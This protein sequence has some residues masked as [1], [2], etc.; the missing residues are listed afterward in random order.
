M[1]RLSE[2]SQLGFPAAC[3]ALSRI[4]QIPEIHSQLNLADA[5]LI[6]HRRSLELQ[7]VSFEQTAAVDFPELTRV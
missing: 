7:Q 5:E 6:R 1:K 4:Q 3:L 2:W